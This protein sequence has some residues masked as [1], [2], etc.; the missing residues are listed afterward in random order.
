MTQKVLVKAYPPTPLKDDLDDYVSF[1]NATPLLVAIAII[2]ATSVVLFKKKFIDDPLFSRAC[3]MLMLIGSVVLDSTEDSSLTTP[4][5]LLHIVVNSL[6]LSY[7]IVLD[8]KEYKRKKTWPSMEL[9][10][11]TGVWLFMAIL[12]WAEYMS[13]RLFK[14]KEYFHVY[15][16]YPVAIALIS[17]I[18]KNLTKK[19]ETDGDELKSESIGNGENAFDDLLRSCL[20]EPQNDDIT[21]VDQK[22]ND[23]TKMLS[24]LVARG[25]EALKIDEQQEAPRQQSG[26]QGQG[27]NE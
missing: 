13:W 3:W 15:Y 8:V 22:I 11:E 9:L 20:K 5:I 18:E 12:S 17:I 6:G 26:A 24:I 16:W 19:G 23:F 21:K 2:G 4:L 1:R 7:W 25:Q 27:S 10:F 14:D